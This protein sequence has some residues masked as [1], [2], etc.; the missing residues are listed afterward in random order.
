MAPCPTMCAFLLRS[1]ARVTIRLSGIR[2]TAQTNIKDGVYTGLC[3]GWDRAMIRRASAQREGARWLRDRRAQAATQT[4]ST[5]DEW[6]LIGLGNA[7]A[8]EL[9]HILA[10]TCEHD[11]PVFNRP[12]MF[13]SGP[14]WSNTMRFSDNVRG[15]FAL[16]P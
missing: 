11:A 6:W 13:S 12:S 8:L 15:C 5:D 10:P 7:L 3:R 2:G 16:L 9:A 14:V 1:Y 4:S